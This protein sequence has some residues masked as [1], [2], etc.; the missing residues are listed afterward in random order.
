MSDELLD[1]SK[2]QMLMV[3][4]IWKRQPGESDKCY[5]MFLIFRDL[6]YDKRTVLEVS[7]VIKGD[8]ELEKALTRHK[9]ICSEW[10]WH[11]RVEAYDL[12]MQEARSE[13]TEKARLELKSEVEELC[14][15]LTKRIKKIANAEEIDDI[16]RLETDLMVIQAL[17]G[18][19]QS[20]QFILN[21]Y[22]TIIGQKIQLSKTPQTES[23][24]WTE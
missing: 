8:A 10:C 13:S 7:R 21:A 17:V 6:P 16:K 24:Q 4:P 22:K 14:L 11:E 12:S 23:L 20:G 19:G 2:K 18:K 5:E 3:E 15:Q 9:T 1:E